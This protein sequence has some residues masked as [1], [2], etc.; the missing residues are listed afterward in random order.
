[1]HV[2][3]NRSCKNQRVNVFCCH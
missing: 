3:F 1:M 2:Y